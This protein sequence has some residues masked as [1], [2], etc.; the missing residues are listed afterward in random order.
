MVLA[1]F[2]VQNSL[3]SLGVLLVWFNILA[4][5]GFHVS[6][7][8]LGFLWLHALQVAHMTPLECDTGL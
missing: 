3:H 7:V 1:S 8:V 2:G 4:F 6:C 5:L